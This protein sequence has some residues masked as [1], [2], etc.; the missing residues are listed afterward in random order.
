VR[1]AASNRKSSGRNG[2][3][4]EKILQN[5]YISFNGFDVP[6]IS[7]GKVKSLLLVRDKLVINGACLSSGKCGANGPL[8]IE[9][10]GERRGG[11]GWLRGLNDAAS[12]A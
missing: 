2:G 7:H 4:R 1:F 8:S 6:P 5:N 9:K 11:K 3:K 10:P 12:D